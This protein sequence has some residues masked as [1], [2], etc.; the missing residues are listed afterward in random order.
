[1]RLMAENSHWARSTFLN[2]RH[3]RAD[4][5]SWQP[6]IKLSSGGGGRLPLDAIILV[7]AI[8]CGWVHFI[9]RETC[10]CG[11]RL[12]RRDNRLEEHINKEV[13]FYTSRWED[14]AARNWRDGMPELWT[15]NRAL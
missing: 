7:Y 4:Q 11:W 12:F 14:K 2:R 8:Q 6:R 3:R 5:V 13:S 15:A 10:H 9:Q 1:M